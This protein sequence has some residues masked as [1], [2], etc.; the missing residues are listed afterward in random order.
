MDTAARRAALLGLLGDL[1]DRTRPVGARLLDQ[2]ERDGYVLESLLLDLN[3]IEPVPAYLARPRGLGGRLPVV[4][5]NHAHGGDYV[6]GKDE[7]I[8]GRTHL[9]TPPYA[10]AL[11]ARGYAVLAIDAWLF[12]E[13]RGR[14]ESELFKEMLWQ[15][16]VL[17]GMMVHDSLRAIDYLATRDDVDLHRLATLGLSMGSTMAW[18]V[19]ALDERVRVCIDIC[20]LT[21]FQALI[22]ARGL[23]GHG[24]YYYVPG[25]LKHFS[26]GDINALIA[27]RPHLSLAGIHDRLT[28]PA[29][30]DRVDAALR[31]VYADL[32]APEAWRLERYATGHFETAAMRAEV[33]AF[34]A[35]WL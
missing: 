2:Q 18:W 8:R 14:S 28:P 13:R 30:L 25:L 23:D 21:D 7:V 9:Q 34:L 26:T 31:A 32:G 6:L 22:E 33:L 5:Y 35:R 3:G 12:G 15:G 24:V 4:L 17:W 11:T 10:A 19:A 27:P 16:R 1:P 29:G 20:C